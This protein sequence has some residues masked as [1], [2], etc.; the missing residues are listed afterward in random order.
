[1]D[2]QT[3]LNPLY[4]HAKLYLM[5]DTGLFIISLMFSYEIAITTMIIHRFR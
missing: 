5:L 4:A 3:G 1:M 2:V